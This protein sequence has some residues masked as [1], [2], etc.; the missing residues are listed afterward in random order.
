[1]IWRPA[2]TAWRGL[3]WAVRSG[4][5]WAT[6]GGEG[7]SPALRRALRRSVAARWPGAVRPF[8]LTLAAL[9]WPAV[10]LRDA[11]ATALQ[12]DPAALGGR[13]RLRLALGAWAVALR[14]SLPPVD[15]FAYRL[16]EP[17]RP[18][19]GCWLHSGDSQVH[20]TRLAA[21]A[22]RALAWDKLAFTEF[23]AAQEAEVVPVLAAYGAEGLIRAFAGGAPPPRDLI[24]K[25]RRGFGSARQVVWRWQDG[26]HVGAPG[27]ELAAW[28]AER[29]RAEDLLVQDL[30]RPPARFGPLAPIRPPEISIYTAEWPDGR[31]C[32]ALALVSLAFEG[33]DGTEY[34]ARQVD[35]ATGCLMPASPGNVAPV[36]PRPPDRVALGPVPVPGWAAILAQIDAL[37]RAL[38]GPGPVLKWDVLLTD[39]GPRL[40]EVN[41]GTGIYVVQAMT[42][43]PITETPIGPALEAWAR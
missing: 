28:L 30:A 43:R 38:P 22:L 2:R 24:V 6:G 7:H 27:G 41:T 17:D 14:C 36:F 10:S 18:G 33:D 19:P 29:A 31:R 9:L 15:Y 13:A 1:M 40:L 5:P 39:L 32:P 35:L 26:R 4:F 20:F 11:L 8:A 23:A 37:H 34:C 21:P 16:F 25:P 42:Q 12:V 3:Q